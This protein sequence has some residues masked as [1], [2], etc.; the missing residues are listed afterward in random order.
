LIVDLERFIKEEERYW[1]ELES[2]LDAL[3]RDPLRRMNLPEIKR[4]HYLYQ[5]TSA[6]LVKVGGSSG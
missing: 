4:F 5:R 6:A 2:A 3:E 1:T